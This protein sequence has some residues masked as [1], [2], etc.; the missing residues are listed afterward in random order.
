MQNEF[1]ELLTMEVPPEDMLV[2]DFSDDMFDMGD[3]LSLLT[4]ENIDTGR[5][6]S[7]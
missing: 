1:A 3:Y 2:N 5:L 7:F 6:P 4:P